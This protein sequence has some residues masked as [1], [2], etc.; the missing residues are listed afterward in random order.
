M[1]N[2]SSSKT[3]ILMQFKHN[4]CRIEDKSHFISSNS[5]AAKAADVSYSSPSSSCAVYDLSYHCLHIYNPRPTS[6][7]AKRLDVSRCHLV[8][9]Y[10]S[11][12]A[13]LC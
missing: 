4:A 6:I 9:S 1:Q 13:T 12:Q 7:V 8:A 11:A 3:E 10:A 2:I 5:A